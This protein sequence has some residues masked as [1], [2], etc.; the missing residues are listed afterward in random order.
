MSNR[1]DAQPRAFDADAIPLSGGKDGDGTAG[2]TVQ[3]LRQRG[4]DIVLAILALVLSIILWLIVTNEQNPPVEGLY[5][6]EVPVRAVNVRGGLDVFG[7]VGTVRV[8]ISA[9][10]D[11]WSRL[12]F[13]AFDAKADLSQSA[14][15]RVE[16]PV[17]VDTRDPQVTVLEVSPKEVPIWLEPRI[18]RQL[19]VKV[20][21]KDGPPE[22]YTSRPGQSSVQNVTVSGP[23]SA[24]SDVDAV[25][26]EVSV[27][28]ARVSVGQQVPLYARSNQGKRITNVRIDPAVVS[29]EVPIDQQ[30]QYKT[31]PVHPIV[32]GQVADGY[33][34]EAIRPD[35][36]IIVLVGTRDALQS[37]SFIQTSPIVVSD[38]RQTINQPVTLVLPEGVSV[39]G[40]P[41]VTVQ[42]I[43]S[44]I[45]G[46]K[47]IRVAPVI[48]G[49]ASN[50]TATVGD[51]TVVVLGPTPALAR[52]GPSDVSVAINATG[53]VSGTAEITPTVTVPTG[54]RI[55]R[56][57]PDRVPVQIRELEPTG[58]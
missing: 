53:Q 56:V 28:G 51:V 23:A 11:V 21:V 19:P 36:A 25:V 13:D 52:L 15:G 26:A 34:V 46:A 6:Y 5:P 39:A 2:G 50:Q 17:R 8:R 22:G 33:W 7:D 29:V 16:V 24:V 35:P 37:V 14:V 18:E 55:Q 31:V 12:R 3:R 45:E 47:S 4:A 40:T 57:T 49:L 27:D 38:A 10:R 42:A 20:E 58:G 43:I 41:T 48:R 1:I 44:A 32:R 9:P 54:T 30:V